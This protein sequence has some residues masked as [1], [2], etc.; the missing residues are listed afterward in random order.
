VTVT[1]FKTKTSV[2][3]LVERWRSSAAR[4]PAS[5]TIEISD[6]CNEVCVHCYQIQGQKGEMT[7]ADIERV[8][9]ELAELGVL[10]LTLSG[11]EATLRDDFLDIVRH[12]RERR[13]AVKLFTNGLTMTRE[14]AHEL[15]LLAVQEVQISLYSH[16]AEMHDWVTRVPGSWQRAVDG[17]R[18][19][20]AERVAVVLKTPLMSINVDGYREYIE[21]ATSIGA[22]Y[23]LDPTLDPRED[24]DRGPEAFR[25][26]D[27][28]FVNVMRDPLLVGQIDRAPRSQRS[29]TKSVCGA[30]SGS[31][32]VEANGE[33]QPCSMLDVDCGHALR[34]GVAAAWEQ[35][36][37]AQSIR[38]LT[39]GDL[40]GCRDCD[41][42]A[43][44]GRCFA[45][46]RAEGGDALGPYASA[47]HR[48]RLM[49]RVETGKEPTIL[50]SSDVSRDA[51]VGPY[52]ERSDGAFEPIADVVTHNDHAFARRHGWVRREAS[53]PPPTTR[54][55]PG[56][57]VQIRRP[58]RK[59]DAIE[60]V[61]P[62][63]LDSRVASDQTQPSDRPSAGA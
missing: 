29:L 26:D 18:H 61:P 36:E 13:F 23:I 35:N 15:A 19:L 46:S 43:Y 24:G 38:A 58:G 8:L 47:C 9:D 6:R 2:A 27:E 5:A 25:I 53:P 56:G 48:A 32:H 63:A 20:V 52:R 39:W 10:F 59:R 17:A 55:T 4:Y 54:A 16:R 12:A 45:M 42:R 22:D 11:G 41:L 31:V 49:Y 44:C 57:L 62:P 1:P 51:A 33:I 30:C 3:G 50:P 28:T 34:D 7:T 60:R 14:L 37:T 21:L 40:H